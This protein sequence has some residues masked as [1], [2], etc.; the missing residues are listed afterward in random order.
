LELINYKNT[1]VKLEREL[2]LSPT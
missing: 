2:G 1:V